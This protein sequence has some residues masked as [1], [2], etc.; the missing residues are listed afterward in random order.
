MFIAYLPKYT[1]DRNGN[2]TKITNAGGFE[3]IYAYDLLD[4]ETSYNEGYG[5]FKNYYDANGNIVRTADA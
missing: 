3:T 1:Y 5:E 2:I 4:R